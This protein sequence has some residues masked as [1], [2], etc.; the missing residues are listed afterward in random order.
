MQARAAVESG[1]VSLG[2]LELVHDQDSINSVA[3]A[4]E[5]LQT[6]LTH[7]SNTQQQTQTSN[8]PDLAAV[9]ANGARASSLC[10]ALQ[11][12]RVSTTADAAAL[13]GHATE[14]K[15]AW[16]AHLDSRREVAA[17]YAALAEEL[18]AAGEQLQGM[19]EAEGGAKLEPSLAMLVEQV[20]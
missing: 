6:A 1:L 17:G 5:Q 16:A 12:A 7:R 3:A 8:A 15:E 14:A 20:S 13:L 18:G 9:R 2:G 11:L 10:D 19:L 4:V